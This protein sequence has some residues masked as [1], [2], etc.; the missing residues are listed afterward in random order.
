MAYLSACREAV[1]LLPPWCP[2]N[3]AG[4]LLAEHR[5]PVDL[6]PLLALERAG[7]LRVD[8]VVV[9]AVDEHHADG[10][11]RREL[12]HVDG[13]GGCHDVE[14]VP[15]APGVGARHALL[16]AFFVMA[17]SITTDVWV[18]AEGLPVRLEQNIGSMR[19]T[20]NFAKFGAT[21]G[22]EAPPAAQTG[23]MTEE[24][25]ATAQQQS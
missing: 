7:G 23:D 16:G 4:A 3:F 22:V 11:G 21:A 10:R 15:A 25:R 17:D 20:M 5:R 24:L 12:P 14:G 13:L 8:V 19:V 9:G 6:H 2:L 1:G 18:D